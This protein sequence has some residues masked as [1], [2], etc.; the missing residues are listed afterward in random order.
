M[1]LLTFIM[2]FLQI[3]NTIFFVI[4]PILIYLFKQY[5]RQVQTPVN[6]VWV[7]LIIVGKIS[8]VWFS[9]RVESNMCY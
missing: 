8:F 9:S 4:P 3:S 2:Y 1:Q 6:V 7:L 5:A